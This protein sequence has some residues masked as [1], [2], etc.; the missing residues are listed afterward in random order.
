MAAQNKPISKE[1]F[2]ANRNF[3]R[4]ACAVAC[5]PAWRRS[6]MLVSLLALPPV[7][8]A[9]DQLL[10]SFASRRSCSCRSAPSAS[11]SSSS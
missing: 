1:A 4:P 11:S 10:R 3:S 8:A 6:S 5:S 2:Y 7:R 9:A